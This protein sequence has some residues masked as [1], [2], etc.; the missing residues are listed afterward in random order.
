MTTDKRILDAIFAGD[1]SAYALFY[2]QCKDLFEGYFLKRFPD[3]QPVL[4]DLYQDSIIDLWT[5]INDGRTK[6]E[7]IRG[8]L[9][10]FLVSIGKNKWFAEIRRSIKDSKLRK[11]KPIR[12]AYTRKEDIPEEER[13]NP[14]THPLQSKR[15][16]KELD[17]RIN[18]WAYETSRKQRTDKEDNEDADLVM[19]IEKQQHVLEEIEKMQEPCRQ[20]ILLTWQEDMTDEQILDAFEGRFTTTSAIKMQRYRCHQKLRLALKPW[21]DALNL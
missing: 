20:L 5:Q 6:R 13:E 18:P 3:S 9:S 4:K 21:Y 2:K 17:T 7:D 16:Q 14:G 10:T 15:Q 11:D 12:K 8:D 19:R 1:S